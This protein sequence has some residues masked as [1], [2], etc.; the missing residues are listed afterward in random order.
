MDI[1][2][3]ALN[4]VTLLP[5]VFGCVEFA[6]SIGVE[7]NKLRWISMILGIVLAMVFQMKDLFPESSPYIQLIF[8]GI[9][10]GLAASGVYSFLNKR[11]PAIQ[12]EEPCAKEDD[13]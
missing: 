9:A 10:V 7:G 5:I 13:L 3:F 1:L 8:F 2:D 12:P 6:K 4:P 11:V